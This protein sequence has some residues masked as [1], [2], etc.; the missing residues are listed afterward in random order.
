MVITLTTGCVLGVC[1]AL[2]LFGAGKGVKAYADNSEANDVNSRA[3][4]ILDA[5]KESLEKARETSKRW[6]TM[7]G[8]KKLFAFDEPLGR[9]IKTFS[10][11]KNVKYANS[12]GLTE[13]AKFRVDKASFA[14]LK[15]EHLQIASMVGGAAGGLA[16]GGAMAF[17]AFG[18]VGT[19]AAASTGTAI[20]TLSG[21]AA[22]NATLAF[23]GGGALAAGGGGMAA[24]ACVL[25]G[26][27]AGPALAIFGCVVGSQ[28]SAKLDQAKSN[29]AKAKKIKEELAVAE[30]ACEGITKRAKLFCKHISDVCEIL[31][32]LLDR[33]DALVKNSGTDYRKYSK[34][35]K[36]LVAEVLSTVQVLKALVDTPI[37]KKDGAIDTA[38]DKIAT[39]AETFIRNAA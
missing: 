21:A 24:G 18:T 2:G 7:L 32:P 12:A 36:D 37:L 19:F 33:L 13:L 34:S 15:D 35:G 3:Q 5:A 17:G 14:E 23:L 10:K 22:T 27:V 16:A 25:G 31:L 39:A 9:F 38:S 29:L 30:T 1:S 6:L 8:K 11:I 20:A 28:A 26:L 4:G